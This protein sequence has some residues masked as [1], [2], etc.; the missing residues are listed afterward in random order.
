MT[1][2][3]WAAEIRKMSDAF[4]WFRPFEND[5]VAGFSG[6]LRC[7]NGKTYLVQVIADKRTFPAIPPKIWLRPSLGTNRLGDDSLCIERMW[8]PDRDTFAQ[9]VL[10]AAAYI[11]YQRQQANC[12]Q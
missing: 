1:S 7:P 9:Q 5:A 12:P 6:G 3:R 4:P 8:R 10:Y 2:A 11:E